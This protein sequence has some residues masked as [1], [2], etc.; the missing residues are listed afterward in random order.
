MLTNK[1]ATKIKVADKKLPAMSGMTVVLKKMYKDERVVFKQADLSR[2]NHMGRLFD[3][4][5]FD[6]VFNCCGETRCGK[7]KEDYIKANFKT[8]ETCITAA[9][10]HKIKKWVEL[11]DARVYDS[12][13]KKA[14]EKSKLKPWTKGSGQRRA[15]EN[16]L[17]SK[18][19]VN[20][21]ILRP[22]IVYGPGDKE[23]L[24][25]RLIV[26]AVYKD[27]KETMKLLWG[28]SLKI[29]CVHVNDV[30]RAMWM[31]AEKADSGT[32]YNLADK[33]DL[34]QGKMNKLLGDIYGIKTGFFNAAK[35]F[36]A[37]MILGTIAEASNDKH[38]PAWTKLCTKNNILNTPLTP[39]MDQE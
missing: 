4:E 26:A 20:Y 35:N 9:A 12:S 3:N 21:C 11:S 14:K 5:Q 39:F 19:P 31:V 27:N 34:D 28:K 2:E 37:K 32:I 23:G 29:N 17:I 8:A 36:A 18:H 30:V 13:V 16:Y 24:T 38:G 1:L 10:K 25:P 6:Y 7:K 33:S 15:V 22:A